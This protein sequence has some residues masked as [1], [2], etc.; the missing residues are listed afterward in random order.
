MSAE[1]SI[2]P[3]PLFMDICRKDRRCSSGETFRNILWNPDR[4]EELK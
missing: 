4:K 3:D 1:A 2:A